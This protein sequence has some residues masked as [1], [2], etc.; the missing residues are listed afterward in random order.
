MRLH[1][2]AQLDPLVVSAASVRLEHAQIVHDDSVVARSLSFSGGRV[3]ESA[4]GALS[5]DLRDHLIFPGLINAHDHLQLNAIPGLEHERPFANS[6]EW[7]DAFE[8]HRLRPDVAAAAS[9]AK[10]TRYHHG[11]LK[12]LLAGATTVAHHDPWDESFERSVFPVSVVQRYGWSHSLRLGARRD[13][14]PPRYGPEVCASYA[15]TASDAPWII[16]LA[17]GTDSVASSELASL[18]AMGCLAPNTVLVH[19]AGLTESDVDTVIAR[20]AAVVWCPSSNVGMLGRTL[21]PR[22]LAVAG[23]L[24]LGTDSR[25][26]GSQDILDELRTAASESDLSHRELLRLVTTDAARALRLP[27]PRL[28]PE[29]LGDCLILHATHDP[30]ETLL[31]ARRAD[32]RAIVRGGVPM[33]ADPDFADWFA[34]CHVATRAVVLDGRPKLMAA[35]LARADLIALEA[36]LSASIDA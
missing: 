30:Y 33:I 26:T 16:H 29:S 32:V 21:D 11:G 28:E 6:Y 13:N 9:V 22:R 14:A 15:A 1:P 12:N 3:V 24:A 8:S 20:G 35:F 17:E 27:A 23:R 7:I 2:L 10:E 34:H 18:D 36:G 19:G 5:I 25:L 4:P 31:A